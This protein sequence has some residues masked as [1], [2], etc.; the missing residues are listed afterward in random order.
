MVDKMCYL[1]TIGRVQKIIDNANGDLDAILDTRRKTILTVP[2][3][4]LM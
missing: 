3:M 1:V 4:L 2:I